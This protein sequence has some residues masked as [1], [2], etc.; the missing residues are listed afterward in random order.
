MLTKKQYKYVLFWQNC[1][2][3]GYRFGR[4]PFLIVPYVP[5]YESSH[6]PECF[7]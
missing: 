1:K 4:M 6:H 3:S 7:L 5:K 2:D